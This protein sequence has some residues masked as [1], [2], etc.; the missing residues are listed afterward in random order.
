MAYFFLVSR[1]RGRDQTHEIVLL[2]SLPGP[3][4]AVPASRHPAID[5][6]HPSTS[7]QV[8]NLTM[9]MKQSKQASKARHS[10]PSST[11]PG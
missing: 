5:N 8:K 4:Y 2:L 3:S 10:S 1:T 11:P 6:T 7:T 9:M